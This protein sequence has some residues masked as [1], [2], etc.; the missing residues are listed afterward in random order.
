MVFIRKDFSENKH[1][2]GKFYTREDIV[3][4]IN[5]FCI[6]TGNEIIADFGCG[7]GIFLSRAYSMLKYLSPRKT[8]SQLLKQ[9]FGVDIDLPLFQYPFSEAST[10]VIQ[11]LNFKPKL[12]CQDFFDIRP[13][14]FPEFDVV[15]GNPPYTRHEKFREITPDYGC[16]LRKVIQTD[17]QKEVP[18]KRAGIHIYFLLH[19]L[20]FIKP[21]GNLGYVVSKSWLDVDYGRQFREFLLKNT[22]IKAVIES[23]VEKWFDDA[24]VNT[25]IVILEKL[26]KE[27]NRNENIIKFAQ[28]LVP[29]DWLIPRDCKCQR[30]RF[31]AVRRIV[32]I[33]ENAK[34]AY[35]DGTIRIVPWK[36]NRLQETFRGNGPELK[37]G[38]YLR[39]PS[40][41]YEI[42]KKAKDSLIPLNKIAEIKRGFTTGC[43]EFFY[44]TRND[45]EKWE[46]EEEFWTHTENGKSIPNYII[47]HP[48]ETSELGIKS[49]QL[50]HYVLIV[51]RDKSELTGTSMLKYIRWGEKQGYSNRTTCLARPR[52]YDLGK[53]VPAKILFL[54]ATSIKPATYICRSGVFH[55]QTFYSVN[56]KNEPW[57]NAVAAILNSTLEGFLFRE[58]LSGAGIALGLGAL[59]S[60]VRDVESLP[61][62]DPRQLER[63]QIRNLERNL[64]KLSSRPVYSV[65]DEIGATDPIDLSM[66]DIRPDR[67]NLDQ[68][69]FGAINLDED[70][71]LRVYRAVIDLMLSRMERAKWKKD[72]F[73]ILHEN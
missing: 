70:E 60:A 42:L 45:I 61:I 12:Y 6:K 5:G 25:V 10:S 13:E 69:V 49:E 11:Y 54:R 1:S 3:D 65:F 47:R 20:K 30:A 17:W 2:L 37:W 22:R 26:N 19:S 24:N 32:D 15:V 43:N 63:S 8:H 14:E 39:A 64:I 56:S 29:L 33:I 46:I 51:N 57:T 7:K 59:W 72:S 4:L 36:Q 9:L 40:I 73:R 16:K 50:D 27:S 34:K 18:P 31:Q 28:F 38:V 55:D 48:R 66:S 71:Q 58:L 44:L 53:K 23:K 41:F 68:I 52:W 62:I 35:N 21:G 67:R